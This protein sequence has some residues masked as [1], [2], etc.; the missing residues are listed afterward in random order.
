[1]KLIKDSRLYLK[2]LSAVAAIILWIAVTYTEDPII[3][4]YL[5][6]IGIVFEGE[7]VLSENGL[8][9]T[10]KDAI[11]PLAVTIRGNRSSVISSIGSIS[12]SVDVSGITSPGQNTAEI[13]Y[14]YPAGAVTLAK[15]RTKEITLKTEKIVSRS[16]LIK[17][18]TRNEEKNTEYIVKT[19]ASASS[20]TVKGAESTVYGIS[21]AKA[22]VD[23]SNVTRSGTQNYSLRFYDSK[24]NVVPENNIIEKSIDAVSAE[25]TVYV[26]KSLPVKIALADGAAENYVLTVK[27]RE[28]SAVEIGVPKDSELSELY[29]YLD[30]S[31]KMENGK[32]ELTISV[33]EG[34]Y[35]QEEKTTFEADCT[36]VPKIL[37]EIEIPVTAENVPAGETVRITPEKIRVSVKGP[38]NLLTQD[39]LSAAVDV[40]ELHPSAYGAAE[41]K[42][43]AAKEE[44]EIIGT[45]TA[46]VYVE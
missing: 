29:A 31:D 35:L 5:G 32:Y 40:S 28:I 23:V 10:D 45:Y 14:S 46:E 43:T 30:E 42:V 15:T 3:S 1:M 13:K 19:T 9:I 17:T 8:I 4:Q 33:P 27:S 37:K 26:R 34:C 12:A 7:D 25:N 39:N 41:V 22:S 44:I 36:L 11:A 21:Y 16:I 6:D 20:V 24:G 38:E 18:E 2:I